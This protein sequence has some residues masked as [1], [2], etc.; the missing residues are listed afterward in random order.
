MQGPGVGCG[1]ES[2]PQLAIAE[3][4]R[5]LGEDLE[6]LLGRLLRD[7][8]DEDELHRTAV[9]RV[10]GHRGLEPQERA[11]RVLEAL[12]APVRDRHTLPQPGRP[13]LL[14]G[15]E[16]VEDEA[17]RNSLVVLEEEPHL[18]EHAFLAADLRVEEDVRRREQLGDAV[19]ARF[20]GRGR[21]LSNAWEW[22]VYP[23]RPAFYRGA[24]LP[25]QPVAGASFPP[26]A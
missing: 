20:R 6:V 4:L 5:E 2:A 3:H 23:D 26:G 22:G 25:T 19:H 9:G 12:D 14:A 16:A 13:K 11:N 1:G 7:E 24:A 15:E 21:C 18:L 17:A 10:E 8:Q